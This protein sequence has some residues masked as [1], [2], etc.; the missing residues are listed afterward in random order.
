[1][2]KQPYHFS[3]R[4]VFVLF[5]VTFYRHVTHANAILLHMSYW[6]SH[7]IYIYE[8]DYVVQISK[9]ISKKNTHVKIMHFG[10]KKIEVRRT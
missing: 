3:L 10:K 4:Q 5:I 8:A 9:C 6:A 2:L 1:M 7:K